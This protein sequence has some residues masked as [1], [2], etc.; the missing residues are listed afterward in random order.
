[1]PEDCIIHIP[2]NKSKNHEIVN[3]YSIYKDTLDGIICKEKTEG[4]YKEFK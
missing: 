2:L 1:M 4:M 3:L